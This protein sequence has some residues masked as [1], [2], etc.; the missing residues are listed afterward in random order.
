V[1]KDVETVQI[2]VCLKWLA[3]MGT[4]ME[5]GRLWL[6]Y[7]NTAILGVAG[8]EIDGGW[9]AFLKRHATTQRKWA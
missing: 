1:R 9:L 7:V 3:K 5:R 4:V 8:V 2:C 6:K